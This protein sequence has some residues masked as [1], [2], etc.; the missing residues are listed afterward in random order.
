MEDPEAAMMRMLYAEHAAALWRYALRL[1]GDQASA[2]DVVQE[3]LLRAWRRQPEGVAVSHLDSGARSPRAWLFTVARNLVIDDRRSARYRNES[4][5]PVVED[6][7]DRAGPDEVSATLDRMTLHAALAGLS[8]DHLAVIRRAYYD[9][10]ATGQIAQELQ[11]PEGTVKSR[12]HY[13]VRA[14]RLNLQEMGVTR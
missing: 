5:T 1:T 8:D 14:L 13:A 10:A 11:I 12:L 7:A 3:T 9:G 6:V 4:G 2:E